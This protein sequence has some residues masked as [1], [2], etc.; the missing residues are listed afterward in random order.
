MAISHFSSERKDILVDLYELS[1]SFTEIGAGIGMHRRPWRVLKVLGLENE[2][3]NLTK[4]PSSD[5]EL[6]EYYG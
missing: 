4:I 5:D 2:L 1:P 6:S 3:S